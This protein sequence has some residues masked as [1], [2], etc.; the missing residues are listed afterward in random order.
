MNVDRLPN[1]I[2][3]TDH[4]ISF[5]HGT[6]ASLLRH[7]AEYPKNKLLNLYLFDRG[8]ARLARNI[9]C[10]PRRSIKYLFRLTYSLRNPIQARTVRDRLDRFA[11]SS[12]HL[13]KQIELLDFVPDVIYSVGCTNPAFELLFSLVHA[14][15]GKVPVIHH[16]LDYL[17][18]GSHVPDTVMQRLSPHLTEIWSLTENLSQEMKPLLERDIQ[19]VRV[20]K[21]DI[22][23]S[24]KTEHHEF[25]SDF[26]VVMT[27]NCWLPNLL[28]DISTAWRWVG[29]QLGG[30]GPIDWLCHPDSIAHVK[31]RGVQIGSE[32]QPR[33]HYLPEE[34]FYQE[35]QQADM[36]IIAFNRELIPEGDYARFSLPSRITELANVGLPMFVAAGPQTET[37]RY[38]KRTGIG[39]C[40]LASNVDLFRKSLLDFIKNRELRAK[41]GM[42]ARQLAVDEFDIQQ[43]RTFLYGKLS[44]I[45]KSRN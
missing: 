5:A 40:A 35:L 3:L 27:G 14:Y 31:K 36:T 43:Y 8:T 29:E 9:R 13:R 22:R 17:R 24:Y 34:Q 11:F 28:S 18:Y 2:L 37:E 10:E 44:S 7:F 32:I 42:N 12:A 4:L 38:V 39:V 41:C 19:I 20:L 15:K 25:N 45:A 33:G 26:K 21:C 30:I 16:F 1:V 6:G 23:P